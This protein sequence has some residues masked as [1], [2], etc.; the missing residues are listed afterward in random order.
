M[1]RNGYT[2]GALIS[3]FNDLSRKCV[4]I[5]FYTR[6]KFYPV[7]GSWLYNRRI[8]PNLFYSYSLLPS[9]NRFALSHIR[10]VV[11]SIILGPIPFPC[12]FFLSI[13]FSLLFSSLLFFPSFLLFRSKPLHLKI[14]PRNRDRDR[15][16]KSRIAKLALHEVSSI[17]YRRLGIEDARRNVA[18]YFYT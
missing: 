16:T 5:H 9:S 12:K 1:E 18:R 2:S 7:Y 17:L 3:R 14:V 4:D 13:F 10:F 15:R 11:Q 6:A 8:L